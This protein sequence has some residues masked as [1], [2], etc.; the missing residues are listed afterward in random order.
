MEKRQKGFTLVE[1]VI[2]IAV[3]AILS[4]VLLPTFSNVRESAKVSSATQRANNAFKEYYA[5]VVT[6][7]TSD[8]IDTVADLEGYVFVVD[9]GAGFADYYF[10]VNSAGQL[11]EATK[12]DYTK[13]GKVFKQKNA[14]TPDT[15]ITYKDGTTKN[16]AISDLTLEETYVVEGVDVYYPIGAKQIYRA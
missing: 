14:T 11:T 7:S 15:Q 12:T 3:I 4:A 1:L 10:V 13:T 6:A 9:N 2:V 8:P 5:T 16:I